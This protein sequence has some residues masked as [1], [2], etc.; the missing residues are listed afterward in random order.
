M[1]AVLP[2]EWRWRGT[3]ASPG[4]PNRAGSNET[5]DVCSRKRRH[6]AGGAT[7]ASWSFGRQPRP[8]GRHSPRL[9]GSSA[10]RRWVT[11]RFLLGAGADPN[12]ASESSSSPVAVAVGGA[13]DDGFA[14]D[15]ARDFVDAG[16]ME[17]DKALFSAA[18]RG[19]L[20]TTEFLLGRGADPNVNLRFAGT[21]LCRATAAG[22]LEMVRLL[23]RH[24]ADVDAGV[25]YIDLTRHTGLS[26]LDLALETGDPAVVSELLHRGAQFDANTL[27]LARA[28]GSSELIR[29]LEGQ[30][31]KRTR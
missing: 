2:G 6:R 24:G 22:N 5:V 1:W 20:K 27:A 31:D 3:T 10:T 18:S 4:G 15:L 7:L 29:L 9:G 8:S 13:T 26:P 21:P 28:S 17:L 23:L 25:D 14:L 12:L 11:L 30:I 16:A 19:F